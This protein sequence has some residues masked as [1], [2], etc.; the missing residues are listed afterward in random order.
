MRFV[1]ILLCP[2][3]SACFQQVSIQQFEARATCLFPGTDI[4]FY[5]KRTWWTKLSPFFMPRPLEQSS[6]WYGCRTDDKA[7]Q[8]MLNVK[9]NGSKSAPAVPLKYARSPVPPLLLPAGCRH[10]R[11]GRLH[12]VVAGRPGRRSRFGDRCNHWK[13]SRIRGLQ[14]LPSSPW[15]GLSPP[16]S[17]HH[18]LCFS[19]SRKVSFT[20]LALVDVR[21]LLLGPA[22]HV[23]TRLCSPLPTSRPFRQ[24]SCTAPR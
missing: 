18:L 8:A 21:R 9:A 23:H 12:T 7:L 17:T 22:T 6:S 19:H 3:M 2:V 13:G 24:R 16:W 15:R 5:H 1:E 11:Y 4:R 14:A 10:I 20:R